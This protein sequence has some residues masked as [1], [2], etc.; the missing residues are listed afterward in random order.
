MA[1]T[2]KRQTTIKNGFYKG[3]VDE[4]A[5]RRKAER[6]EKKSRKPKANILKTLFEITVSLLRI[7]GYIVLFF[8]SSVGLTALLNTNIRTILL[9]MVG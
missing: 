7:F 4:A 3:Y 5:L 1:K 9:N 8:L 6:D 2:M